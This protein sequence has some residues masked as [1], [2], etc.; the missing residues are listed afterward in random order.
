MANA[1]GWSVVANSSK[2]NVGIDAALTAWG[3]TTRN[4]TPAVWQQSKTTCC[5]SWMESKLAT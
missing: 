2:M 5:D 4:L 3:V 1:I